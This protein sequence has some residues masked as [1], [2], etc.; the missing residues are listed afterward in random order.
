MSAPPGTLALVQDPL[1]SSLDPEPPRPGAAHRRGD[2]GTRHPLD[3]RQG[4]PQPRPVRTKA[5]SK[6][7][8]RH[9]RCVDAAKDG[10]QRGANMVVLS[11]ASSRQANSDLAGGRC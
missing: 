4:L 1:S 6:S 7:S 2:G 5:A 8:G 11:S 3:G 10:L 9:L